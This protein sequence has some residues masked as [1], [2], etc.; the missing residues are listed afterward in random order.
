MVITVY[1]TRISLHMRLYTRGGRG[2]GGACGLT[3]IIVGNDYGNQ[4]SI[5]RQGCCISHSANTFG[6]V[7]HSIILSAM[8]K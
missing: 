4:S 8:G 2:G 6:K 3:V 7:M 1:R 5:P